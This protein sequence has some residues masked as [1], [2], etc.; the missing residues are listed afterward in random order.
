M[1]RI[2]GVPL[3]ATVTSI[4]TRTKA[5]LRPFFYFVFPPEV[6]NDAPQTI[7]TAL[8]VPKDR[9]GALQNAVVGRFPNVTVIDVTET[10]RIISEV[11]RKLSAIIR[12]FMSMSIAAG[13]LIIISSL[14]ATRFARVRE[15]VYYKVLGARGVFV[16]KVFTLENILIGLISAGV[17]LVLAQTG[18]LIVSKTVLD[19]R[20]EPFWRAGGMMVA[21]TAAFVFLIGLISSV[22]IVKKR[23]VIFLREQSDE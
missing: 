18:S 22:S 2:Q 20:Y 21:A 23:P 19:I 11:L 3:Q 10:I 14:L 13:T 12:F 9:I 16:L 17:A 1:F 15:G 5:S 6:L 4:R 7:F 8:R